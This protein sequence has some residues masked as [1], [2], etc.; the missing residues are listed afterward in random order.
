MLRIS[1][2]KNEKEKLFKLRMHGHCGFDIEGRDIVCAAASILC[3][4]LVKVLEENS[5]GLSYAKVDI[6]KGACDIAFI[7]ERE[8]LR[9]FDDTFATVETGLRLLEKRFGENVEIV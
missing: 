5:E 8:H 4:T 3:L 2:E 7:P 1:I 6:K 9:F